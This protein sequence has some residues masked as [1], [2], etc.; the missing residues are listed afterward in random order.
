[1]VD[2]LYEFHLVYQ[3]VVADDVGIALVELAVTSFLG[4]VGTPYGLYLVSLEREYQLFAV[5]DYITCE[6]H[7]EVITESFLAELGCQLGCIAAQQFLVG[8]LAEVV[9]RVLYLE[10]KLVTLF[11]IFA[12]QCREV[13][14]CGSL[15]LL[16]AEQVERFAYGVEYIVSF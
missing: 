2:E 3:R 11:A 14:H 6:R 9:A 5:H 4:T 1:M 10:K 13:L 16:E 12:H 8:Y 15:Y 7:G